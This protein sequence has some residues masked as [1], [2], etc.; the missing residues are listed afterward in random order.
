M[1]KKSVLWISFLCGLILLLSGLEGS[2]LLITRVYLPEQM[3]TDNQARLMQRW[4]KEDPYRPPQDQIITPEK[5][6]RFLRVNDSLA[7]YLKE[8]KKQFEE[9]SWQIAFN[10]IKMQ[11]RW[12]GI[13]YQALVQ[14]DL[15]PKEY[16]WISERVID[17]WI[18]RWKEESLE[19]LQSFGWEFEDTTPAQERPVNYDILLPHEDELNQIFDILWPEQPLVNEGQ[20]DSSLS[21]QP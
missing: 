19:K 15:S 20:S 8:L 16:N 10:M 2:Y 9:N 11:P 12:A 3:Q 4:E 6:S 7:V 5:L 18:Y 1:P 17:F 13:K 21:R 14:N